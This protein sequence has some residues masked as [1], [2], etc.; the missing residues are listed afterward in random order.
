MNGVIKSVD[1]KTSKKGKKYWA[2]KLDN[3]QEAL[4]FNTDHSASA[5]EFLGKEVEIVTEELPSQNP[6]FGPSHVIR[7]I[8]EVITQA[9]KQAGHFTLEQDM[10]I[11]R[12]AIFK[13]VADQAFNTVLSKTEWN[14]MSPVDF[15]L[16]VHNTHVDLTEWGLHYIQTGEAWQRPTET[17]VA[18]TAE[19]EFGF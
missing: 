7:E 8:K 9:K 1:P 18:P 3:G 13:A 4:A 2:V 14:K 6:N 19:E 11:S 12:L 5:F 10:K 17:T 16:E 15:M